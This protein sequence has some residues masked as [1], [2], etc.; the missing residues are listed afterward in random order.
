MSKETIM[1]YLLL[2]L[3]ILLCWETAMAQEARL[4]N[5]KTGKNITLEALA[6][7]LGKYDLIFFG[8]FHDNATIHGLQRDLLPLLDNK[9]ELVM[10]FEMFERDVQSELD[11][12]VEGWIPEEEFLAKSRPWSNYDTDYKPLIE[13]ARAHKLS[14]VAAN[15][16]RRLAGQLV[17]QGLSF[18]DQLD[19]SELK[20]LPARHT[21]PEGEYKRAFYA[22]MQ[23]MGNHGM[24]SS[25]EL[26]YQAQ[27][28]KDDAMAESIVQAFD[29]KPKARIIHFNGDFHSKAFLGTVTRV[30]AARP[31]LKIA[32]ITPIYRPDWQT[33]K[34]SKE[35]KKAGTYLIFLPA[36]AEGENP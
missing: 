30:N 5:T 6:K 4:I 9:R 1:K 23:G 10:S 26:L 22:T 31:K 33:G 19:E 18:R 16:P 25:L 3:T 35:E 13:Y 14:V 20:W 17:R 21:Y 24:D 11:A 32:V 27:C 12:Y 15:V 34:P 7:D 8:E 28:L 36:P 2:L 29:L